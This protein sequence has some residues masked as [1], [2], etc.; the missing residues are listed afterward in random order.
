ELD[1]DVTALL[2]LRGDPLDD[3]ACS[4]DELAGETDD[5]PEIP[6]HQTS[7]RA[8]GEVSGGTASMAQIIAAAPMIPRAGDERDL[9]RGLCSRAS[10]STS[11][12]RRGNPRVRGTRDS[13]R[14]TSRRRS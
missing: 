11:S 7:S 8:Q 14:R 3:E 6:V 13:S 5:E 1:R 2:A 4:E 9:P 10:A 12:G